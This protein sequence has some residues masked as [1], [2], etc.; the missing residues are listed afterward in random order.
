M[1]DTAV[2]VAQPAK[3]PILLPQEPVARRAA[4]ASATPEERIFTEQPSILVETFA[5]PA[6]EL[7]TLKIGRGD[8]L[9]TL[10]RKNNLSIGSL[11]SMARLDQ[12][13]QYFR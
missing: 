1:Q 12:A 9:D 2:A 13:G 8:T 6:F 3:E 11:A 7:L 5:E 10:F 4:D